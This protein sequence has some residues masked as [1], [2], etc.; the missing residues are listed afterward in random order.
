MRSI[1][2]YTLA[3]ALVALLL[4]VIAPPSGLGL[5]VTAWKPAEGR[6]SA[7]QV[8]DRTHKSDR[9]QIPRASGR[10]ITPPAAPVPVGCEPVFS[11]LSKEKQ[12][13]FPGRCVA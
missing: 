3:S 6:T 13:N 7:P 8:V 2:S 9:L 4:T 12:A 10:Q 1:V 11:A 5:G